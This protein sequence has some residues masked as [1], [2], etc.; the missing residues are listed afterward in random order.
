M[1]EPVISYPGA[2]WRFWEFIKPYIPKDIK[3]FREPFFG[4]GSISLSIADDPDFK[5]ERMVAGDLAPEIWALWTGIR[6][7][8][9]DVKDIVIR[10][11]REKCPTQ[12]IATSFPTYLMTEAKIL[13]KEYR[14]S[15]TDV[16]LDNWVK[17]KNIDGETLDALNAYVTAVEEGKKFWNWAETVDCSTLSIPERAARTYI[18]NKISFSGM[19]DS[20]SMSRDQLMGFTPEEST[21]RI[22]TA[23][24]LLQR[25]E[26]KNCSFEETMKDVDHNNTFIFLDPPYYKQENSG[27]YGKNGD[28]HHGFPHDHFAEFTRNTDCR[29]FVTYDDSIKVRQM[30]NGKAV[31]NN[32]KCVIMP[33]VI[34]GGYTLAGKT[35][36]DA[37]AGEELFIANYD[38]EAI[39]NGENCEDLI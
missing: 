4:G 24:P 10:W 14:E 30:F 23:Q 32:R 18:I 28:T 37:L 12:A 3:D 36:E 35:S 13:E 11:F 38:I 17:A 33:F 27:L 7:N 2:K 19:G 21:N 26:I 8:A 34:P 1:A 29:W 15:K 5:L 20:G 16:T 22:L 25:I 6:N 9:P 31:Y 39:E